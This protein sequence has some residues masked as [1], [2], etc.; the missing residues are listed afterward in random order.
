MSSELKLIERIRRRALLPRAAGLVLGIGD[1][2]AIFRQRGASD[3]LLFTTDLLLEGTHFLRATHTAA[4]VG[5]KALA[6]GLSD[7]AA[8]G[9]APRFCLVSLGLAPWQ[10]ERWVE[11]FYSGLLRLSRR[12][13]TPLAGGDLGRGAVAMCDIVVCGSVPRGQALLRSG[14]R[15]R[16]AIYVSGRLGGS[17]LGLERGKSAA[18]KKHTRPEPRLELGRFLRERL[19]ATAAMDL[20]DGLSLDLRRLCLASRVAAEI[21]APPRYRGASLEQALHGGEDYELLFTVPERRRVPAEFAGVALTRIGILR[22]GRPGAVKLDGQPLRP[23]G[24]DHLRNS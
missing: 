3:D 16:D 13:Q 7:I 6:R 11:G 5:W 18:W 2:C 23:L 21:T 22:T 15:S 8:M 12:E 19:G 24:Y 4:D 1:D 9:G 17:A 10:T 20:S 14:A